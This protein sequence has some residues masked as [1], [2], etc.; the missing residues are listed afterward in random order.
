MKQTLILLIGIAMICILGC[1]SCKK[2][3]VT[4]APDNPYGLPNATQTGANMFACRV[5]GHNVVAKY[6]FYDIGGWMSSGRDTLNVFATISGRITLGSINKNRIINIPYKLGDSTQT[7][8]YYGTDTTCSGLINYINISK[9]V[10]TI[11]YTKIDTIN[12]IVSGIFNCNIPI[13]NC[14]SLNLTDGR[15]DIKYHF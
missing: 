4:V 5:N 12:L 13:P 9:A 15:I 2:N 11:T 6:D 8:F 3:T 7:L 1:S 10:G 14:D